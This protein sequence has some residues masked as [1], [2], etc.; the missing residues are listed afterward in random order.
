MTVKWGQQQSIFLEKL[1][2]M[3]A[4]LGYPSEAGS[5]HDFYDGLQSVMYLCLY[6]FPYTAYEDMRF[7]QASLVLMK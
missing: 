2:F 4:S 3:I 5:N 1:I 7:V 6:I